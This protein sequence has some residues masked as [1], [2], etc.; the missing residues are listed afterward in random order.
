MTRHQETPGLGDGIDL[1]IS[2]WITGFNG[3]SLTSPGREKWR[4][5]RDGGDFDQ[6]TAATITPRA[7]VNAVREA[8]EYFEQNRQALF[9]PAAGAQENNKK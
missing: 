5:K 7:V 8:L 2:S 4:V 3:R 9:A 1:R 6:F